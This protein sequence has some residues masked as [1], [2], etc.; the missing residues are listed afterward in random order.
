MPPECYPKKKKKGNRT[1]TRNDVKIIHKSTKSIKRLAVVPS[2]H[3]QA[4]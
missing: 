4:A 3:P 1:I 2:A